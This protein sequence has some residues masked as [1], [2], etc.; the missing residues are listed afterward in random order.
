[1]YAKVYIKE[2]KVTLSIGVSTY[3]YNKNVNKIGY[4][5]NRL[6][7]TYSHNTGFLYKV[8]NG[9]RIHIVS[10]RTEDTESATGEWIDRVREQYPE[11]YKDY[12]DATL[13]MRGI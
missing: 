8:M 1:D 12:V 13:K 10:Y 7:Y 5:K 2:D 11:I 6:V 9:R 4:K 3:V